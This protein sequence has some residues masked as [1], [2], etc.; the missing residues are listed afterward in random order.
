MHTEFFY[1]YI[2]NKSFAFDLDAA[3]T[4]W[5]WE[6]IIPIS[7]FLHLL[8]SA[9]SHLLNHPMKLKSERE[10]LNVDELMK[11]LDIGEAL[12]NNSHW[13]KMSDAF[14]IAIFQFTSFSKVIKENGKDEALYLAPFTF[15][16]EAIRSPALSI[17]DRKKLIHCAFNLF[18]WNYQNVIEDKNDKWQPA[19]S[20]TC[21]GTLI[22]T[23][24]FLIRCM[25]LCFG[26]TAA[27]DVGGKIPLDR[28]GSHVLENY[29]GFIRVASKNH[30]TPDMMMTHAVRAMILQQN[31]SDLDINI[32]HDNRENV[33]GVLVKEEMEKFHYFDDIETDKMIDM[34]LNDKGKEMPELTNKIDKYNNDITSMIEYPRIYYP[35]EFSSKQPSIRIKGEKSMTKEI[36]LPPFVFTPCPNQNASSPSFDDK[37]VCSVDGVKWGAYPFP[38]PN[39]FN[40]VCKCCD[41]PDF[42]A[43][44]SLS[45]ME[46]SLF[47]PS[48]GKYF[49]P[50]WYSTQEEKDEAMRSIR[51]KML[52][53]TSTQ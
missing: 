20:E 9:R 42:N 2:C 17:P 4:E 1:K 24:I 29:F 15:L 53:Y 27:L 44:P 26:L 38:P 32:K 5:K 12:N 35:G 11:L 33:G 52:P 31:L 21:E 13:A 37:F 22:G 47:V 19:F 39:Y 28:I 49:V 25:N 46:G 48:A 16:N 43:R 10:K 14:A 30:H 3:I 45:S 23:K 7:D 18:K 6:E 36:D 41:V 50:T 34:L 40:E 51:M 8:K